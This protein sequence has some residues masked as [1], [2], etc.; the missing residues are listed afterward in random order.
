MKTCDHCGEPLPAGS[1]K[2]RR[3]CSGRCRIAAFRA[4]A[5]PDGPRGDRAAPG[6]S[7]ALH[8]GPIVCPGC[9]RVIGERDAE[10][11]SLR[12]RWI[13][14]DGR[15]RWNIYAELRTLRVPLPCT[16]LC[17]SCRAEIPVAMSRSRHVRK[18]P[19]TPVLP[20]AVRR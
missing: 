9:A 13:V 2:D 18:L 7:E 5:V 6:A 20:G 14:A 10:A 4:R 16:L 3:T 17:P 1:R 15:C 12:G 19:G 8:A 11:I